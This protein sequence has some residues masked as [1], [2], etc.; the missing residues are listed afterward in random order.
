MAWTGDLLPCGRFLEPKISL[1]DHTFAESW[2]YIV[3]ETAKLEMH[4]GCNVCKKRHG[5]TVCGASCLAESGDMTKKPA[6]LCEMTDA[7]YRLLMPYV[8]PE[9]QAEFLKL[10]GE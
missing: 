9:E 7:Y 3:E 5:C 4:A 8:R 2:K 6:Y 10:L 1:L